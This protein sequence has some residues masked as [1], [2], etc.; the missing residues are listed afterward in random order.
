MPLIY[1]FRLIPSKPVCGTAGYKVDGNSFDKFS[2][3]I[4]EIITKNIKPNNKKLR[5][6]VNDVKESIPKTL[7]RT[8]N[9]SIAHINIL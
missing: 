6:P 3:V 1:E 5:I 4:V 2:D 9:E 8:I 7:N